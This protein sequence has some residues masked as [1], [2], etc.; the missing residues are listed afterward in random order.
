MLKID[1]EILLDYLDG[2]ANTAGI[3]Y[4]EEW[5]SESEEN[6]IYFE[7]IKKAWNTP[8]LNFPKPNT[9]EALKKVLARIENPNRQATIFKLDSVRLE[10]SYLQI[11]FH[12][13]FTKAA[14]AILIMVGVAYLMSYIFLKRDTA[15]VHIVSK[16]IQEIELSDGS[17][18]TLDS[19]SSFDY[20]ESF[21]GSDSREVSLKGE[22]YFEVA[23][24]ENAPFIVHAK[25]GLIKVLGTKFNIR[26]WEISDEV[27]VAVVEGKVSLQN[28]T[29]I[30]GKNV[31]LSEGKMSC[32]TED[33][34]LTNPVDVDISKYLSWLNR[35]IYFQNAPFTDVIDQIE[36][37]YNK[38]IT[39]SDAAL[40]NTRIT[41]F[42]EN[43]PLEE[44]LKLICMLMNMKYEVKGDSVKLFPVE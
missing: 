27:I 11:M 9:E 16:Q 41:V 10:K 14:A 26:A 35:E 8:P 21:S 19:G 25:N 20:P 38:D 12:S 36:R 40:L 30:G 2:S 34:N 24:N 15:R 5:L 43:K 22:A 28:K 6:R 29:K 7:R 3:K 13:K 4:I 23:K 18:V 31:V 37:W 32:L 42:I 33:G 17:K 1:W 44:N 39:L